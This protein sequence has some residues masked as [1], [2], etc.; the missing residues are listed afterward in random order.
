MRLRRLIGKETVA[1][2]VMVAMSAGCTLLLFELVVHAVEAYRGPILPGGPRTAAYQEWDPVVEKRHRAGVTQRYA[3]PEHPEGHVTI[4]TNNLGLREDEPTSQAPSP[5]AGR[6]L[7]L[8]D[9]HTDGLVDNEE[10]WPNVLERATGREVLNA[11]VSGYFTWQYLLW[12]REYGRALAPELVVL[13]YYVGND[14]LDAGGPRLSRGSDG[15]WSLDASL[16]SATAEPVT[17]GMRIAAARRRLRTLCRSCALVSLVVNRVLGSRPMFE[18]R[19]YLRGEDEEARRRFLAASRACLGCVWQSLEQRWALEGDP[20]RYTRELEATEA[21]LRLLRDDVRASGAEL[22]V[23]IIPSK[24]QVEARAEELAAPAAELLGLPDA[25]PA[26]DDRVQED[27]RALLE[28]LDV[29]VIDT[30]EALRAEH[31]R[32]GDKLYYDGDWHL[33]VTGSRVVGEAVAAALTRTI[34][35]GDG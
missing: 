17:G 19:G 7:A 3:W 23:A 9:S 13:G 26:F 28:R 18:E 5:G 10:T 35:P 25:G 32:T 24:L 4:R 11:G 20:G 27:V 33:D 30:G 8:G 12:W 2:G 29:T 15:I 16:P 31:A 14:L 22:L 34:G 21:L 6:V 1:R